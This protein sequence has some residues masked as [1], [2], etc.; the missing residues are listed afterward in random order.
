MSH[1]TFLQAEW[2]ALYE[3][4]RRAERL[5]HADA[6][7]SCF[8]ARRC[9]ELSVAWIYKHDSVLRLP[10]QDNLS[11]LIHEPTFKTTAGEASQS[12]LLQARPLQDE[13]LASGRSRVPRPD[14]SFAR[15]SS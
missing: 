13:V 11:A 2:P 12:R 3:A 15:S 9:L 14:G 8:Y 4:A 5:A 10:Y 1:F 6:R 7:A